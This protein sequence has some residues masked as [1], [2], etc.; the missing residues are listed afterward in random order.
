[1]LLETAILRRG[2]ARRVVETFVV[3]F[4]AFGTG[5]RELEA[6]GEALRAVFRVDGMMSEGVEV[7]EGELPR[8]G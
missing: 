4:D 8:N 7:R 2:L 1:M 3:V 5:I 6:L